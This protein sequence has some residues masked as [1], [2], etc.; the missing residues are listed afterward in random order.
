MVPEGPI[1]KLVISKGPPVVS[2][3]AQVLPFQNISPLPLYPG[4]QY[5]LL[6]CASK[7]GPPHIHEKGCGRRLALKPTVLHAVPFHLAI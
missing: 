7:V 3:L 5:R 6:P 4:V 2:I 1:T